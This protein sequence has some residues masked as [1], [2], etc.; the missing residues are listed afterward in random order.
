MSIR[1][2][3]WVLIVVGLLLGLGMS[4]ITAALGPGMLHQTEGFKGT[5]EQ[6]ANFVLLFALVILFGVNA[7]IA[8]IVMVKTGRRSRWAIGLMI[9]LFLLIAGVGFNILSDNK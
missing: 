6:G 4:Y 1:R 9:V 2:S 5:A 8:G 7:F 3:G